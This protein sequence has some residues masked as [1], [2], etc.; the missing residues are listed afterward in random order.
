MIR[1]NPERIAANPHAF[2]A[3]GQCAVE[4]FAPAAGDFLQIELISLEIP[5][6]ALEYLDPSGRQMPVQIGN[7]K[8]QPILCLSFR[9]RIGDRPNTEFVALQC[10][11]GPLWFRRKR[12]YASPRAS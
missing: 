7:G 2:V 4:L 8:A 6:G 5:F 10:R 3:L 1:C 12:K 11:A 9:D